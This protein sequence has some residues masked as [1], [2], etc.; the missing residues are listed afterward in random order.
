MSWSITANSPLIGAVD[1]DGNETDL[2]IRVV[3]ARDGF[4]KD[5]AAAASQEVM[6]LLESA[7]ASYLESGKARVPERATDDERQ[8]LSLWTQG[9]AVP[10]PQRLTDAMAADVKEEFFGEDLEDLS[11]E[12]ILERWTIL[13]RSTRALFADY[14]RSVDAQ[15][16]SGKWIA[17]S[18]SPEARDALAELMSG[19][20]DTVVFQRLA[21]EAAGNEEDRS[22]LVE[23]QLENLFADLEGAYKVA[24]KNADEQGEPSSELQS[25]PTK[26]K[27]SASAAQ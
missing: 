1:D 5:N 2:L 17:I 6:D 25:Q 18:E 16:K 22:E 14:L 21:L 11:Q 13:D 19:I 10:I 3:E 4:G 12:D 27:K 23:F 8:F 7:L 26:K 9:L 24:K 15:T 20:L